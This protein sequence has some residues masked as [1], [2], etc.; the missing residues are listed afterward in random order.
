MHG[1]Y[2]VL[3]FLPLTGCNVNALELF[4]VTDESGSVGYSNYQ[5][6][7]SFVHDIVN[8]FDIGPD[9]VQVGLMSYSSPYTF[10]FY[11]NTYSS[12]GPVLTAISSLAYGG[13]NGGGTDTAG[14]LE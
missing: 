6:M 3:P 8:A 12:K 2:Q 5:I 10:Q 11:L 7:K 9:D 13:G 1:Y 4:F 14:A